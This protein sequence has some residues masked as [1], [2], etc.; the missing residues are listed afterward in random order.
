[1]VMECP[2]CGYS[3]SGLPRQYNCPECGFRYDCDGIVIQPSRRGWMI[4]VVLNLLL[5]G[6]G[7]FVWLRQGLLT[8]FLCGGIGAIVAG[9]R[10]GPHRLV[11][12]SRDELRII[13]R[14][15]REEAFSMI[16]VRGAKWSRISGSVSII[17]DQDRNLAVLPFAFFRSHSEAK[18]LVS[19]I[20]EMKR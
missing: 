6:F 16:E 13:W 5:F 20:T 2:R 18:T 14:K 10:A 17:G 1:M 7:V 8:L 15:S 11:F 4:L 12:V 3:L 9:I 19:A